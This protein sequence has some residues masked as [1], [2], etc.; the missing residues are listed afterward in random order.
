MKVRGYTEADWE[1]VKEI[2]NLSKVDELKGS[3]DLRAFIPLER[4]PRNLRLF[5]ESRIVV[6]EESETILGFGGS[7]GTYISWLFVHP[8]HR[9]RGVARMILHHILDRLE[10]TA[11]LNVFK[12]NR[13]ARAL[14]RQFGFELERDFTG[15]LN[16][17][18]TEA[19]TLRRDKPVHTKK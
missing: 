4:D 14:Y 18:R 9:R 15:N 19:M 2:Y 8:R 13:A 17:F 16:G 11:T 7:S 5:R 6:V 3:V 12:N 1:D 10:G